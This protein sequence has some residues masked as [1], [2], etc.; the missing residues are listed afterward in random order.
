MLNVIFLG[1][2]IAFDSAHI[3]VR[4]QRYFFRCVQ[5]QCFNF[6][7]N[8]IRQLIASGCKQLDAVKFDTVMRCRNHHTG[9]CSHRTHQIGN[10]RRWNHTQLHSICPNRTNSCTQSGFQNIRRNSGIL[11][12]D[13]FRLVLGF[14]RQ[15]QCGCPTNLHG[16]F[17][18]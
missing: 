13:N 15:N 7:F 16:K 11:P 2:F 12:D 9:I 8:C 4:L 17:T 10:A 6:F 5:N 14:F 3:G 18:S 1:V